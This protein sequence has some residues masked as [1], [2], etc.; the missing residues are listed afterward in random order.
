MESPDDIKLKALNKAYKEKSEDYEALYKQ[1]NAAQNA[2]DKNN[3]QRQIDDLHED[4][5]KIYKDIGK[6]KSYSFLSL[7]QILTPNLDTA[8]IQTAYKQIADKSFDV[9]Q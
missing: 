4:L 7:P 1:L 6:L 8:T 3:L 2:Q 9:M 5:Q